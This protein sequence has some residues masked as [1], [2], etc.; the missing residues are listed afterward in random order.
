MGTEGKVG[1]VSVFR[2]K[3]EEEKEEEE[4]EEGGGRPRWWRGRV[5][6]EESWIPTAQGH[7]RTN[8]YRVK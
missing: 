2:E 7:F 1:G 8:K 6:V 4:E 5:V 3:E